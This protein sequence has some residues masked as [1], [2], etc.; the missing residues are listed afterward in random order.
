V[1]ERLLWVNNPAE[2][3]RHYRDG[4]S[5]PEDFCPDDARALAIAES[6]PR[7]QFLARNIAE[8]QGEPI[9]LLEA[10]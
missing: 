9:E 6:L 5:K 10:A 2:Y 4:G 7:A 1:R 8:Q 3:A